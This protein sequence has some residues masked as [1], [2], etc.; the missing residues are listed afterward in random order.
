MKHTIQNL[1]GRYTCH[2]FDVHDGAFAKEVVLTLDEKSSDAASGHSAYQYSSYTVDGSPIYVGSAV[3]NGNQIALSFRNIA[4]GKESDHGVATGVASHDR[5]NKGMV[6]TILHLFYYQSEY[7]GGGNG[8]ATC[9][10]Q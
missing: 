10:K 8:T 2:G 5:D 1:S 4:P 7:A 9:I 6:H 3:A